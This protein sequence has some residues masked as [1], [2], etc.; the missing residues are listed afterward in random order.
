M[1]EEKSKRARYSVGQPLE[2][3]FSES[4]VGRDL[5]VIHGHCL[6]PR[7]GFVFVPCGNRHFH[8]LE[9]LNQRN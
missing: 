6:L 3:C 5:L 1:T 4:I 2:K 7:L 8:Q 9:Q